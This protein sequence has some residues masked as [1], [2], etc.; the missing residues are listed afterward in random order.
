M[1]LKTKSV[2]DV[3][4]KTRLV[5]FHGAVLPVANECKQEIRFIFSHKFNREKRV[6]A[7]VELEVVCGYAKRTFL[8]LAR[9]TVCACNIRV[10]CV[11][12]IVR[13]IIC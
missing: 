4:R 6:D 7:S 10:V 12:C 13:D 5:D 8:A 11:V 2:R 9:A 1:R 3:K